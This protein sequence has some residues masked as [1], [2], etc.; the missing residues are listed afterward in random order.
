MW[1]K[2][3][4]QSTSQFLAEPRAKDAGDTKAEPEDSK[5]R[6]RP[7]LFN[8]AIHSGATVTMQIC[9]HGHPTPDVQWFYNGQLLPA[10]S[11]DGRRVIWTDELGERRSKALA[12]VFA[13]KRSFCAS[14]ASLFASK[15][16]HF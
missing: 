5:P 9:A 6:I 7:G 16:E 4:T 10:E 8:Q 1:R 15:S 3:Q 12:Y 14:N 13:M 2:K 11:N